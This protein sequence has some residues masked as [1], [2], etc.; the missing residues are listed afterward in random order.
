M[1][2]KVKVHPGGRMPE[3]HG[4]CFD[5][6]TTKRV[7]MK[8]GEVQ[9]ISLGVSI[10]LPEGVHG[11]VAARS[12]TALKWG[13]IPANGIGIIENDYNGDGDV[14][15]LVAY[16][17]RDTEIPAYTRIAQFRT[18]CRMPDVELVQ[19]DSLE[20]DDRGGYGSTGQA[21]KR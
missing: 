10:E 5:L 17:L 1:Q 9:V 12:S 6:A 15:G 20:N 21:A 18:M 13:I 16:A 8:A 19:V 7:K 11:I 4:E 3:R 2:V 14:W